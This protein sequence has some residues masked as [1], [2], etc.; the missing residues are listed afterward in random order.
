MHKISKVAKSFGQ[1]LKIFLK[2]NCQKICTIQIFVVPLPSISPTNVYDALQLMNYRGISSPIKI[3]AHNIL[4]GLFT[5][6]KVILYY[7]YGN[8]H[9]QERR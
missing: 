3:L 9:Y 6:R 2:N 7:I 8:I 1:L 4:I 5:T